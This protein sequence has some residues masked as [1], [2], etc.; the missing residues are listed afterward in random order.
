MTE[1]SHVRILIALILMFTWLGLSSNTTSAA[2]NC[3]NVTC[4][5]LFPDAMGCPATTSGSVKILPDGKSTVET[6]KSGTAD[7]DAKWARTY[8]KSGGNRYAA[9]SLRY[10]CTNYCNNQSISSPNPIAS[11]STIGVFTPMHA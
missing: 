5:G 6:R 7:C 11:S 8:N 3:K 1:Y 2:G 4:E 9:A 10:G